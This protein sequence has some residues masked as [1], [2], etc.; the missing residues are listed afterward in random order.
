[1]AQIGQGLDTLHQVAATRASTSLPSLEERQS[2]LSGWA[3]VEREPELVLRVGLCSAAWLSHSINA[4]MAAEAGTE[5]AGDD[6]VHGDVRSDNLCFIGGQVV[7]V[8]R[9]WACRGNGIIDIAGW[10]PSLHLKGGPPP[11]TIL[12]DQPN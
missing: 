8:D 3:R 2:S 4:L 11:N 9:N 7:L 12:P 5:L 1:M 10:L 6:L